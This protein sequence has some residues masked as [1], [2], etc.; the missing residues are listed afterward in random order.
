MAN[1]RIWR[2]LLKPKFIFRGVKIQQ[3]QENPFKP[4][5]KKEGMYH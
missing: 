2:N 4:K 1:K 5:K 3:L